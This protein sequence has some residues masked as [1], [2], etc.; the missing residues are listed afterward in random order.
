MRIKVKP[1]ECIGCA[2]CE[3]ACG[4]HWDE[5]F[6]LISSSILL[7]RA[8]EKKDYMGVIVKTEEDLFLGRPEGTAV[9]KVGEIQKQ[10]AGAVPRRN[11]SSSGRPATFARARAR[12]RS[13]SRY[14]LAMRSTWSEGVTMDTMYYGD[15]L[16][17]DLPSGKTEEVD[18]GPEMLTDNGP[19]LA[20]G[21]ALY[22]EYEA[23]DPLVMGSGLLTGTTAPASSLGFVL[24]KSPLTGSLP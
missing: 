10:G 13:A 4:F 2:L 9:M 14:V 20:A 7:Y 24:G 5:A 12:T 8:E 15:T 11:R 6:S 18:F 17:V 22:S 23:D 1:L 19:G 16:I 3:L 21:L